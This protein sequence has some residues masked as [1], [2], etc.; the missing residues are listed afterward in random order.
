MNDVILVCYCPGIDKRAEAAFKVS[1]KGKPT[2]K[3]YKGRYGIADFCDFLRKQGI[4]G[5]IIEYA[6]AISKSSG[7]FAYYMRWNLEGKVEIQYN[8]LTG[9]RLI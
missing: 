6:R 4:S 9:K 7:K 1:A 3:M 8:L 5:E 2:P